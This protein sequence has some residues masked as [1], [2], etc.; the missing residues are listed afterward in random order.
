VAVQGAVLYCTHHP[1]TLCTKM[2]INAGIERIYYLEGYPDE[3]SGQMLEEAGV[4][5]EQLSPE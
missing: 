3:L 5:T 4:G 1:C 2:I